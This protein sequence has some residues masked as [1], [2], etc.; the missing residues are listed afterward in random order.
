ME[1]DA[2]NKVLAYLSISD[3][4]DPVAQ[5]RLA[6]FKNMLNYTGSEIEF[7]TLLENLT[8][9]SNYDKH[10]QRYVSTHGLRF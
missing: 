1:I 9:T 6:A 7:G 4:N 5:Q 3:E 8:T 2:H 10:L